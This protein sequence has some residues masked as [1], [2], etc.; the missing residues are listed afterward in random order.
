MERDEFEAMF[1]RLDELQDEAMDRAEDERGP[2]D[3]ETPRSMYYT[4]KDLGIAEAKAVI[5][6]RVTVE[7]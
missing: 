3:E 1:E 2:S 5:R 7:D 6:E 4:G